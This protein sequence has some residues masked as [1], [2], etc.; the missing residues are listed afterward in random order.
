MDTKINKQEINI[1]SELSVKEINSIEEL[2]QIKP[3]WNALLSK[4]ESPTAYLT[5]EWL[6]TWWSCFN[7]SN[8]KL[9]ILAVRE[10]EEL[11]GLA[12]LMEVEISIAGIKI[13]K[14]E[15]ISMMRF[16][17][18]PSNLAGSLDF[19]IK[20]KRHNEVL[21]TIFSYLKNN[22]K[23]WKYLRL[24]P[25][26]SNSSSIPVLECISKEQRF[27]FHRRRV[28]LNARIPIDTT[29]NEYC[30]QRGSNFLKKFKSLEK[31]IMRSGNLKYLDIN[32][33]TSLETAF[34]TLADIERSSWKSKHGLSVYHSMYKDFFPK[35][36]KVCSENGMLRLW[37]LELNGK[38]IAYDLSIT[39]S[40]KI[41]SLVST[42][43]ENFAKYSPGHLLSYYA[44][45][46][47]F[48]EK[49][50]EINLLWGHIPVK[51]KWTSTFDRF[52]EIFIFNRGFIP[53]IL[54]FLFHKLKYYRIY[55]FL[56]NKYFYFKNTHGF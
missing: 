51:S 33:P 10:N 18:S 20:T 14:I 37:I 23:G 1:N 43:D 36:A 42:Y 8:K 9:L 45:N 4:S 27:S 39:Y 17:Y 2:Q 5:Y 41:E 16:A 52:D 50:Q 55:R 22:I 32:S 44:F 26:N 49:L 6:T 38:G 19:I 54:Y 28:F 21:S 56:A 31:K 24:H 13:R 48:E 11:I 30:Q 46:K 29:W 40:G 3:E 15:F 35:L 25:I 47:Y 7:S 34:K 53:K 12:P